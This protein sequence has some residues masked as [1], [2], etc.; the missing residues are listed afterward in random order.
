[1]LVSTCLSI[2][3]VSAIPVW[4]NEIHYDNAGGDTG[5]F[6]EIAGAAGIDLAGGELQFYN[7]ASGTVYETKAL[8]GTLADSGN[9]YGFLSFFVSGIQNGAPDGVALA[10][11]GSLLQFLSYEGSF[12]AIGGAAA[13]KTSTDIGVAE[14]NSTAVGTS[15]Q[16]LGTP[17]SGT[18]KAPSTASP[19]V[20]NVGQVLP[21]LLQSDESDPVPDSTSTLG[22]LGAALFLAFSLRRFRR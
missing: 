10:L 1:M 2:S 14:S 11:G 6:V 17:D 13:G 20:Q 12:D 21:E 5:E 8:S 15:L 7:G 16:L 18:W 19:G 3:S 4:I 9:G 22:L